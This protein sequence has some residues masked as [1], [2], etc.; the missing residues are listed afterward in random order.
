MPV[1]IGAT[2]G[3]YQIVEQIGAGGMATV[4]KA[5]HTRLDRTV[6]IKMMHANFTQD[7]NFRARFEREARIVARLEHPNIVPVYDYDEIDQQPYLVMKFVEGR[8]LKDRLAEGALSLDEILRVMDKVAAALNYAHSRDVL[9]R[10]MKPSNI[11]LD[12]AGEPYITDFGLA[13]IMQAGE[14]TMSADVMIGTPHYISP[15]Q[16][17][18][19]PQID[20][21]AD[22]YSFGVIL[23]ELVTG[24]VPFTGDSAYAIVHKQIYAA[25]PA[26]DEL[27]PEIPRAVAEVLIRALAKDP[28]ERY[29]TPAALMDAFRQA[30]VASGLKALDDDRHTQAL[31][32]GAA[33]SDRT[34]G[35]GQYQKD[36]TPSGYANP[37]AEYTPGGKKV[38]QIPVIPAPGLNELTPGQRLDK[39]MHDISQRTR[40][41]SEDVQRNSTV[42]KVTEEIKKRVSIEKGRTSD[43]RRF[44]NIDVGSQV[45]EQRAAAGSSQQ[46]AGARPVRVV[47]KVVAR[48]WSADEVYVR[49]RVTRRIQRRA[50]FFT[51]LTIYLFAMVTLFNAQSAIQ[52]ELRAGFAQ[53]DETF[54]VADDLPV[55][56]AVALG[57]VAVEAPVVEAPVED[58]AAAATD[59]VLPEDVPIA[60]QIMPLA[61]IPITPVIA[62]IWG[63]GLLSHGLTTFYHSGSRWE[64]RRRRLNRALTVRYGPDWID[65]V[66]GRSYK[67]IRAQV[68]KPSDERLE[69]LTHLV[70]VL[71]LIPAVQL[72]WP[73]VQQ[74]I[75]NF[76]R[77]ANT[78]AAGFFNTAN[79]PAGFTVIMLITLAVHVL[80]VGVSTVFGGEAQE[81]LFQR[82]LE[83]ERARVGLPSLSGVAVKRKNDADDADDLDGKPKREGDQAGGV[84]LTADGELTDSFID[85]MRRQQRGRQG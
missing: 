69:L 82:E 7:P 78:D 47:P 20:A 3:Q 79:V 52:D 27:N 37:P 39:F 76:L 46:S 81:R 57:A 22:G 66:D 72:L 8:T 24:R 63:M 23:Y 74:V 10:D 34:P 42:Q 53:I 80:V 2:L 50:G 62:L 40:Q 68:N 51:H 45:R 83:R 26:P 67:R 16:A 43:G 35:G 29:P 15:E 6:A 28:A 54:E 84:R 71:T 70:A 85:E 31:E 11:I 25:P 30:V 44:L 4:Y 38:V 5:T 58:T 49:G 56:E 12:A 77:Y 13:R 73:P 55:D 1:T 61:D 21:R 64:A 18:G 65:H 48:D 9:H 33:L 32:R 36:A 41:V 75:V 60:D 17:Q 19:L 59:L 14:S